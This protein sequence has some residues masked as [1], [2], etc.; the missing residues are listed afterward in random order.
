MKKYKNNRLDRAARRGWDK[1][2]WH[3]HMYHHMQDRQP[4]DLLHDAGNPKL[5]LRD[6][7][8]GWAGRMQGGSRARGHMYTYG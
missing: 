8:E 6:H 2:Q 7:L 4:G 1:L 5:V 3:G